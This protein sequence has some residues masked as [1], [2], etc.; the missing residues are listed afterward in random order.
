[1]TLE[2]QIEE[3]NV[4]S[5]ML[6]KSARLLCA[7]RL[8]QC[9]LEAGFHKGAARRLDWVCGPQHDLCLSGLAPSTSWQLQTCAFLG[10]QAG[11]CCAVL[12]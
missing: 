4:S 7:Q 2:Q 10:A 9:V 6:T 11:A 8:A 12:T 3:L 5:A 1:M